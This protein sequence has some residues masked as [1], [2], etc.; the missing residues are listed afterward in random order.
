ME[1][2]TLKKVDAGAEPTPVQVRVRGLRKRYGDIKALDGVDFDVLQG[3]VFGLLGPNGAGKTTT[4]EIIEGLRH[5]DAGEVNVCGHDPAREPQQ[6]KRRIGV[7][8]QS[9]ALPDKITVGEAMNLFSSLYSRNADPDELLD[10][11]GLSEKSGSS[12]DSLSG[13]QQQRLAVALALI[14]DPELVVLDE[15][16][17][18]LDA[19]ARRELYGLIRLMQRRGKTFI[20]TTHYIEEAERLCDRVA[21]IDHGRVIAL[22]TPGRLI[23]KARGQSRI[24]FRTG[25]EVEIARLRQIPFVHGVSEEQGTYVLRTASAPRAT[26]ELIRWLEAESVELLD[27]NIRRPSLED[28]FIELTGRGI[29]E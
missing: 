9:T 24:E 2:M 13:G 10:I 16:T 12:F 25:A 23:S 11:A 6:I 27:L 8:L 4:V 21:I 20:L 1:A 17:A 28:V 19:Q 5:A 15:P 22:D 29:R 18:G 3:E 7:A 14:N 26:I